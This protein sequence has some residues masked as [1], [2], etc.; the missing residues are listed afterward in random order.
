MTSSASRVLESTD[1]NHTQIMLTGTPGA[2]L[3]SL[4]T[5][6]NQ[7]FSAFHTVPYAFRRI[8]IQS[9]ILRKY[10]ANPPITTK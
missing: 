9:K 6:T 1:V 4:L 7:K 8:V 5:L 2:H 10:H 3:A